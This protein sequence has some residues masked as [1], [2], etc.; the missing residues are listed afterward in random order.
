MSR[1][2]ASPPRQAL[3]S[4]LFAL[5]LAVRLATP[6]GFMPGE[7]GGQ[8]ALVECPDI[9]PHLRPAIA[10][11]HGGMHHAP[12]RGEDG[13]KTAS[14]STVCPFAAG[15][16][17]AGPLPAPLLAIAPPDWSKLPVAEAVPTAPNIV[18]RPA[19]PPPA[20]APPID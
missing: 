11:D 14:A 7:A 18:A 19:P 9:Y 5:L 17:A 20:R 13:K 4:A 3:L 6:F 8:L 1:K 15:M 16:A 10:A 2:A 12:G